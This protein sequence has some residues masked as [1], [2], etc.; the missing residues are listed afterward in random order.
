MTTQGYS[1]K[2]TFPHLD[3]PDFYASM[4]SMNMASLVVLHESG[5]VSDELAAEIAAATRA[6]IEAEEAPG[7]RRS[8]DYLDFE[9]ELLSA[10][11]P[12]A[13][14]LH[15]GRS[16]QDMLSTGVSL[17]LCAA[18]LALFDGLLAARESLLDFAAQH[19]DTIIPI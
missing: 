11:G 6:I 18:H 19:V 1:L 9:R 8:H 16:R 12:Q 7:A 13:S 10:V 14:W 2:I 15:V 4:S 17:W 3:V 5:I